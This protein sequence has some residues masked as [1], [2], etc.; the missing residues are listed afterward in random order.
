MKLYAITHEGF[1]RYC[2]ARAYGIMDY[3]DLVNETVLRAF[4]GFDTLKNRK[5][6]SGF[7]YGIASNII[8]NELRVK[9]RTEYKDE[10]KQYRIEEN[11]A[12]KK[13]EIE[14]LYRAL[15]KL[16]EEQEE[17]VV[18]F[19]ISGYSIK[20]IAEMQKATVSAV[21]Q[22]LKRGREK[23]T[24][25]LKVDEEI[26]IVMEIRKTGTLFSLFF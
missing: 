6:F 10:V 24:E 12:E 16:P 13:L 8:K 18:L 9:G 11:K 20:E 25:L 22:R 21:K 26:S 15:A 2:K 14:A 3:H 17:A 5:A 23:L 19:E 7:L 4:D 1:V